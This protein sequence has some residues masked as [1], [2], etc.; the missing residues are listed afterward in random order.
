M[1]EINDKKFY[2][3]SKNNTSTEYI[4]KDRLSTSIKLTYSSYC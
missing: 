4:K 1:H 3:P 2:F